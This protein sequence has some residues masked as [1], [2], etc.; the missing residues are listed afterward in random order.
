MFGNWKRRRNRDPALAG[1]AEAMAVKGHGAKFGRKQEDAVAGLL[2]QRSIDEAARVAGISSRTLLRW[3][4]MPEFQAAYRQACRAAYSQSAARSQQAS[5]PAVATLLKIM[6]DP[7]APA[8]SRVRAAHYVLN[9]A[10]KAIEIED[11][12]ERIQRLEEMDPGP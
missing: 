9:H 7:N 1:E 3:L 8:S 4:Q 11:L 2:S 5:G 6:V 10:T 12:E